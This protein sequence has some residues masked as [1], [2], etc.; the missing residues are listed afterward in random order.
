MDTYCHCH[1]GVDGYREV[2][3]QRQAELILQRNEES[4]VC[5]IP[6]VVEVLR[7]YLEVNTGVQPLSGNEVGLISYTD[8]ES[9]GLTLVAHPVVLM[10]TA[11]LLQREIAAYVV[12]GEPPFAFF[13]SCAEG[14]PAGAA[15][16]REVQAAVV[17]VLVHTQRSAL[18]VAHARHRDIIFAVVKHARHRGSTHGYSVDCHVGV[19]L[20]VILGS[21]KAY[22]TRAYHVYGND[23]IRIVIDFDGTRQHSFLVGAGDGIVA[24]FGILQNYRFIS[25]SQKFP[26][27]HHGKVCVSG[28]GLQRY[29]AFLKDGV[30]K[31]GIRWG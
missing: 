2:A 6:I 21:G 8:L 26:V 9:G 20:P 13:V 25:F 11:A 16:R 14:V 15:A 27:V 10:R 7:S 24:I 17:G 3:A 30:I 5:D 23:I 1:T 28:I 29:G 22:G 31:S 12:E 19:H 18:A 4:Q